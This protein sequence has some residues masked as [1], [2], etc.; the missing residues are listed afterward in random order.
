MKILKWGGVSQTFIVK[1]FFDMALVG[2]GT[3]IYSFR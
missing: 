3:Y 2:V 1:K